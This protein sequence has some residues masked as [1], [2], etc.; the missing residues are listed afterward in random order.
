MFQNVIYTFISPCVPIC[1]FAIN[2]TMVSQATDIISQPPTVTTAFIYT[3]Q[4]LDRED[5]SSY[6]LTINARDPTSSPLSATAQLTVSVTDVNDNA[7]RFPLESYV[8]TVTEGRAGSLI[9]VFNVRRLVANSIDVFTSTFISTSFI[10]LG[11]R[12]GR[13]S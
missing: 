1:R 5:V 9:G 12:P 4:G 6:Q 10:I 11:D 8:I 2:I 3:V 13:R 7:P